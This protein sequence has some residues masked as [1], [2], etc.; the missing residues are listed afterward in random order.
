MQI[1]ISMI[2]ARLYVQTE[3]QARNW[4]KNQTGVLEITHEIKV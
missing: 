3:K 4:K 1:T 2:P